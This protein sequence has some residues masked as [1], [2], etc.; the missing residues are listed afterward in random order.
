VVCAAGGRLTAVCSSVVCAAGGRRTAV[1]CSVVCAA[2][3]ARRQPAL[4]N[5]CKESAC[6]VRGH[7]SGNC[8]SAGAAEHNMR[9]ASKV[10]LG[11][12]CVPLCHPVVK[13]FSH[14]IFAENSEGKHILT[15]RV[16][17]SSAICRPSKRTAVFAN[18]PSLLLVQLVK[19]ALL[20][21]GS[22]LITGFQN[23]D[24]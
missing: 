20:S 15:V 4:V 21:V 3:G 5:C 7:Y 18:R 19:F 22:L 23:V 1:C 10:V 6:V 24:Q 17:C 14:S 13:P 9:D 16:V 8:V 2:G 12:W 11:L